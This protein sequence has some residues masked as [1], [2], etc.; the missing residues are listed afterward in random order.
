MK[1][2]LTRHWE[3]KE[4]KNGI[5]QWH[6]PW[7]LTDLWKEQAKKLSEILLEEKI[8]IIFTSDLKRSFDTA[9]IIKTGRNIDLV[10]TK[11][12]RERTFWIYDWK[13]KNKIWFYTDPS[14]FDFPQN[15]ESFEDVYN[16]AYGF[17]K[18]LYKNYFGKNILIVSHDDIWKCLFWVITWKNI[19]NIQ[20]IKSMKK[21]SITILNIDNNYNTEV[22]KYSD[23]SHL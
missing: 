2:I 6:L 15:W 9:N 21:A 7:K 8:D 12:I 16:R 22:L 18:Y 20:K 5:L 23:I 17:I 13:E 14:K 10:L 1:I 4:T 11:Q 3:T 19:E